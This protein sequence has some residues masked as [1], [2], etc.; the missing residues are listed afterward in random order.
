MVCGCKKPSGGCVNGHNGTYTPKRYMHNWLLPNDPPPQKIGRIYVCRYC[1]S[2]FNTS[3][4]VKCEQHFTESTKL[5][6][7]K[8]LW[9]LQQELQ[10]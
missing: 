2:E 4:A 10:Q 9:Q 6:E 3:W 1:Q 7:A 5:T 8:Q